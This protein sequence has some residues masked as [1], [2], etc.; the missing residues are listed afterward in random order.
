MDW[1]TRRRGHNPPRGPS[2]DWFNMFSEAL[3]NIFLVTSFCGECAYKFTYAVSINKG[4]E[5]N[6]MRICEELD[7]PAVRS[8]CD[9]AS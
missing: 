6:S 3:G 5:K 4:V 1:D 7:G 8:P 2:A 9:R